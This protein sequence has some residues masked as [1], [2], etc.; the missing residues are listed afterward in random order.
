MYVVPYTYIS[1]RPAAEQP[2]LAAKEVKYNS[3]LIYLFLHGSETFT[4]SQLT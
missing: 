4:M 1:L 2:V 3:D